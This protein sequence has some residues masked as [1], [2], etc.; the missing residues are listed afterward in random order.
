[1][2]RVSFRSK[3]LVAALVLASAALGWLRFDSYQVGSWYDDAHYVVLADSLA[4]G[5]GCRLINYP[6]APPER[7]YPPGW[8]LMLAPFARFLPAQ[9]EIWKALP[10]ALWLAS[11]PLAARLFAS[12][13]GSPYWETLT[14]L[15]A[16]NPMLGLAGVLLSEAA[17]VFLSL[18]ALNLF[19][20][21]GGLPRDGGGRCGRLLAAVAVAAYA[22]MARTIGL[23]LALAFLGFL[24]WRR[25]FKEC[26]AVAA[27]AACALAPQ[28]WLSRHGG[29]ILSP[30]YQ[31]Q[32]SSGGSLK[33]EPALI[34]RTA[35]AYFHP[36][37]ADA[38]APSVDPFFA[39]V[40]ARI[41]VP[42]AQYLVDGL[43]L[44]ALAI[45]L[46]RRARRVGARELYVILYLAVL[47]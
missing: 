20:A 8:P 22:Q 23:S 40:C 18:L 47:L 21:W 13:V 33:A 39:A 45:G 3:L 37:L 2:A 16:L 41:G 44:L 1:M 30:A 43:L 24:L 4:A 5:R 27:V 26:V 19:E 36:L 29:G 17:Y 31:A 12:R 25:R 42:S 38:V 15:F 9:Y 11:I 46:A 28:F 35:R 34:L 10:F 14:A 6:D 32:F 7:I